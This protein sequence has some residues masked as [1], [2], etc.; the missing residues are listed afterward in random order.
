MKV[1]HSRTTSYFIL[2]PDYW[3][4]TEDLLT[5]RLDS[6][7]GY[8]RE[9]VIREK[10]KKYMDGLMPIALRMKRWAEWN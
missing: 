9:G 8:G 2:S 4:Y 3:V 6:I 1:L 5:L 7:G 10:I